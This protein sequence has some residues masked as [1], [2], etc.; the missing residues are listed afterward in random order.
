MRPAFS[1][2]AALVA[3]AC[4]FAACKEAPRSVTPT[5]GTLDTF[6]DGNTASVQGAQWEGVAEGGGEGSTVALSVQ[7]GG[8]STIAYALAA[9]GFRSEGATPQTVTGVRLPLTQAPR[10]ADPDRG[11]ITTDVRGF[12]GL[13][14]A[15]KGRPGTYIVQ[16]GDARI[17]DFNYYNAYVEVSENW[18]EFRLPFSGFR[19]EAFGAQ[20]P[21]SGEQITHIAI[22]TSAPGDI[23]FGVDDVRFY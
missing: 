2:A 12:T 20:V 1:P 9:T 19:Q 14:L 8:F 10:R 3:A 21:W 11:D 7:R 23:S 4:L 13:A 17:S 6:E 16:I 5:D 18:T 15:L 22:Y